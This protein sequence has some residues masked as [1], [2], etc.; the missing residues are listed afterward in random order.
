MA[1][2]TV[3]FPRVIVSQGTQTDDSVSA[4]HKELKQWMSLLVNAI[5]CMYAHFIGNKPKSEQQCL[6]RDFDIGYEIRC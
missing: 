2:I 6:G 5:H 1:F 3:P 4:C